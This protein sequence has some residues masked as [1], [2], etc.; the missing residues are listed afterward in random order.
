MF[1]TPFGMKSDLVSDKGIDGVVYIMSI[2]KI[3]SNNEQQEKYKYSRD[4]VATFLREIGRFPILTAEQEV[5]YGRKI[6]QMLTLL[7]TK[8]KLKAQLDREPTIG[9]WANKVQLTRELLSKQ[10]QQGRIAKRKMIE[11]NLRLVVHVAKKYQDRDMEFL[12]LIQEGSLGLERGVEK[13]D[14][15]KGYKFSTYAYWWIRQ[16]I[17]RSIAE[18]ARIVRLPVHMTE[19][20]NKIKRAQTEL[21][22]KLGHT[23]NVAQIA[24]ALS[25]SP[26]Q[27]REYLRLTRKPRSLEMA[28]GEDKDT[29]LK[30]TLKYEG[31]TSESY[32]EGKL[33]SEEINKLLLELTPQERKIITLRFGLIDGNQLSLSQA[34]ERVSLSRQRIRQIEQRALTK[35]RKHKYKMG[36]YLN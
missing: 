34:G 36:S 27:V 24:K 5:Q 22:Q 20:L 13:F 26:E 7:E 17:T 3:K 28:I 35:L 23:P 8:E 30:D 29:E 18:K 19:K 2:T 1:T 31:L 9:E 4:I 11:S 16:G 10:L 21:S 32:V 14:P 12:D 25:F 33:L 15:T 6:Q